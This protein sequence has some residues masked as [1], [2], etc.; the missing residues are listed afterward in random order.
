MK[1]ISSLNL[2]ADI[3]IFEI[4]LEAFDPSIKTLKFMPFV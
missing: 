1:E 2:F 3:T 4:L